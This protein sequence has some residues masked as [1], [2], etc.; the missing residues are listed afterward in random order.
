MY[1]K[2]MTVSCNSHWVSKF[3]LTFEN[4]FL[5][6]NSVVFISVLISCTCNN[7]CTEGAK[8]VICTRLILKE[9]HSVTLHK[10]VEWKVID[11]VTKLVDVEATGYV[12]DVLDGLSVSRV[13]QI[14]WETLL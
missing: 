1:K 12:I 2:D 3:N 8:E 13:E 14:L 5:L 11:G 6:C 10:S 7:R 4:A 9:P